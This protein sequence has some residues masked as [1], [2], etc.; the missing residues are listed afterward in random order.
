MFAPAVEENGHVEHNTV[1]VA[2]SLLWPQSKVRY[3][4]TYTR[5][6]GRSTLGD[7]VFYETEWIS[8]KLRALAEYGSQIAHPARRPWFYDLVDLREWYA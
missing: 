8:R 3:Y 1:G 2:A 4:L 7:E 6:H 5:T